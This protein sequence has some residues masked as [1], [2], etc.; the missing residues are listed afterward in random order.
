MHPS[1]LC[2]HAAANIKAASSHSMRALSKESQRDHHLCL[3][4]RR[5][6]RFVM[7]LAPVKADRMRPARQ[8]R[9]SAV[10]LSVGLSI[11]RQC[12][13]E[14]H[15]YCRTASSSSLVKRCKSGIC[16]RRCRR[17]LP[18]DSASLSGSIEIGLP[19][20]CFRRIG[21]TG[22]CKRGGRSTAYLSM[23]LGRASLVVVRTLARV[24]MRRER[25][26]SS[27][28]LRDDYRNQFDSTVIIGDDG[29]TVPDASQSTQYL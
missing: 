28:P 14:V 26:I 21:R 29:R 22:K 4:Q 23:Q 18:Q 12:K 5:S 11:K 20:P 8:P 9:S 2:T 24:S 16:P 27:S 15:T 17:R 19:F 10:R 13:G 7:P 1:P 3:S 6:R 25:D